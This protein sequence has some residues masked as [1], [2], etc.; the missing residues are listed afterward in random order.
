MFGTIRPLIR[1][2]SLEDVTHLRTTPLKDF[3]VEDLR[4]MIGQKISL[5]ILIP[6]ALET[7]KDDPFAEGDYFPG[8]LLM[9]VLKLSDVFWCDHQ[10]YRKIVDSVI[11]DALAKSREDVPTDVFK[12]LEEVKIRFKL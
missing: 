2:P 5:P 4:I 11:M 8:D 1:H 6:L 7:L 9:N 12:L 10:A 3:S